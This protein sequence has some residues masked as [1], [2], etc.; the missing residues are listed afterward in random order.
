MTA[1]HSTDIDS[2]TH[3]SVRQHYNNTEFSFCN[4]FEDNFIVWLIKE[5]TKESHNELHVRTFT[6][7]VAS[8]SSYP[9]GG[10]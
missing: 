4:L 1:N 2:D 3:L 6:Q 5:A 9:L 10:R 7:R 8:G